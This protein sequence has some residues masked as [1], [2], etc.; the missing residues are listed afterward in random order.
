M[1]DEALMQNVRE[2]NIDSA[3]ILYDRYSKRLYN[4]FL[5]ISFDKQL[6]QDML[7][8]TF[9]RMIKYRKSFKVE[10]PFQAWIFQIARNVFADE[11]KEKKIKTNEDVDVYNM[12][13]GGD[14][15][16]SPNHEEREKK[17]YQ[18][19]N[20]LDTESKEIL[21]LSRFQG[22]KYEHIAQVL[23]L[24]VSAVKVKVHRAIKKLRVYYLE[25]EQ[26]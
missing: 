20:R 9:L 11:L 10:K 12:E 23:N 5:K 22:M 17:L 21:V 7:Q 4:Y 1:T 19:L 26:I 2:N 15:A 16:D 25:I 13:M 14:S 6:S 18:A 24:S 3:S 8:T